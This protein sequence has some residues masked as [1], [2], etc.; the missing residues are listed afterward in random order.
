M[1]L[2]IAVGFAVLLLISTSTAQA[3]EFPS[4]DEVAAKIKLLTD[5]QLIDCLK[6]ESATCSLKDRYLD[7]AVITGELSDRKHVDLLIS[8]YREGDELQRYY[9]VQSLWQI[10]DPQVVTFMRSIAFEHLGR[11]MDDSDTFYPLDYLARRCDPRALARL[12]RQVNFKRYTPMGCIYWSGTVRSFGSCNY[13]AA[14]PN[15]VRSLD[16]V[17]LNITGA[18]EEGLQK[19]FP[20]SCLH[21]HSIG[22]EQQC[23]KNL[24]KERPEPK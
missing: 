6:G 18:A 19:F 15:L 23:Y 8:A 3:P 7:S 20:G 11:G 2:R 17:C 1:K 24:L 4:D 13:H 10:D 16:A 14:A 22:E 5:Q 9:L 12:N 21:A